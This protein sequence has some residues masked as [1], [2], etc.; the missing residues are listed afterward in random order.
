MIRFLRP[1]ALAA[2]ILTA[3]TVASAQAQSNTS[4]A[5]GWRTVIY[6]IYGW[7]PIFGADV[8]LPEVPGEPG[9]GGGP[10]I[11]PTIPSAHVSGNF[12]GAA[13]ARFRLERRRMS[14]D[15]SFLWAGMSGTAATPRASL[16]ADTIAGK[17]LGGVRVLPSFFI[18]GGVQRLALKMT[19]T[20][21]EFPSETWKPGIWNPVIGLT[22]RPEFGS[23]LR[24]MA[25]G[26]FGGFGNDTRTGELTF[27][28][29]W[30]PAS[31]FL[32]GGGYGFMR[33]RA[34]GTIRNKAVHL[35]QT[36]QG[37][38]LSIGIPF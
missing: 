15:G 23:K 28:A 11:P 25:Q 1:A 22:F 18:D 30:K 3:A 27:A 8:R 24:L 10:S 31:H 4:D 7:L 36:L 38:I 33:V 26:D 32:L 6:P 5:N 12:N 29:E 14:V 37:P 9:T 20:V 13:A 19:A 2:G 35:R 34:D 21:Q 16:R 17:L